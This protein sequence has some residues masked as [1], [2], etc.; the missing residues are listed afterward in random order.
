MSTAADKIESLVSD[1]Y[2]HRQQTHTQRSDLGDSPGLER[3][4]IPALPVGN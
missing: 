4:R 3:G 2:G 1:S